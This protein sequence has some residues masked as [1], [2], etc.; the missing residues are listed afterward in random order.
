MSPKKEQGGKRSRPAG[1]AK[2]SKSQRA[3]KT[4]QEPRGKL[5]SMLEYE[6]V[7]RSKGAK[8]PPLTSETSEKRPRPSSKGKSKLRAIFEYEGVTRQEARTKEALRES[9]QKLRVIFDSIAAGVTI[10]DLE[11]N[12]IEMNKGALR[13]HGFSS[14][15]EVIGRNGLELIAEKDRARAIE[16]WTARFKD[17]SDKAVSDHYTLLKADGSQFEAAASESLLRDK[18]G[19]PEGFIT[20]ARDITERKRAEELVRASEAKLRA[21]FESI[22]DA[23]TIVDLEGNIVEVNDIMC[24]M[25]GYRRED[26]IGK[27][28]WDIID[29]QY[30]DTIVNDL[31]KQIKGE[32]PKEAPVYKFS[33]ADGR[34]YYAEL[35]VS[36]IRD[37]SGKATGFLTIHNDITER[38]RMQQALRESEEMARGMLESAAT[39]IYL[40]QDRVFQYVSPLFTEIS[41]YSSSE[42]IGENPLDYVHPEDRENVRKK[43]I[44]DLK[45]RNSLPH[46]FRFMR[47]DGEPV[48]ILEKVASIEY[49]GKPAA[50]ASFMDITEQKRAEAELEKSMEKLRIIIESIGDMLF[51]TDLE[52]KF[53]NVND[54]AVRLLGYGKEEDLIGKS[55]VDC[56]AEKDRSKVAL[57]MGKALA[58]QSSVEI[59]EYTLLT[60]DGRELDAES[61]IDILRDCS[62]QV[63]GLIITTRD[64]TERKRMQEAVRASEEKLSIMFESIRDG[65]VV[66][67]LLGNIIDANEATAAITGYPREKLIGM[68]GLELI[69]PEYHQMAAEVMGK[70]TEGE[71]DT[72][73]LE[74]KFVT[75]DGAEVDAEFSTAI[76]YNGDREATGFVSIARDIGER[77]RME[78]E[79]EKSAEKLRLVIESIGDMLFITDLDLNFSNVN[80]AAV[81]QLGYTT[82]E[83]LAGKNAMEPVVE[84]DRTR[85]AIELGKALAEERGV[86]IIEYS[87]QAVDGRKFDVEANAEILRDC[88]NMV[89]GLIISARD[90]TERKQMLEAIRDSEEKLRGIFDT[91]P[92]GITFTD[93]QGTILELNEAMLRMYG[94]SNKEELIGRNAIDFVSKEYHETV[95]LLGMEA[96][97]EGHDI[98]RIEYQLVNAAG[99][100][101]DVEL[102]AARL[103]DS[104]G[105]P[106][107]WVNVSRDVTERKQAEQAVRESERRFRTIFESIVDGLTVTDLGGNIVD[108]NEAALQLHGY[109]DKQDLIGKNT[110]EY[111]VAEVD[112][113]R[114]IK[115]ALEAIKEDRPLERAEYKL[116]R[117]DGTEFDGEFSTAI[118]RDD[119]GKA[120]GHIGMTRDITERKQAEEAIRQ[121]EEKLRIM[122][123]SMRDAI[124]LTDTTGTIVEVNDAAV[125][126]HGY[127]SRE[128]II[129]KNGLDLVAESNRQQVAEAAINQ[130]KGE[131]SEGIVE[132]HILL[133]ADGT[134]FESESSRAILRDSEGNTTGFISVERD[135]TER[136]QM[137]EQVRDTV[138]KLRTMFDSMNDAATIVDMT[139]NIVDANE[140]AVRLHGY[141]SREEMVGMPGADLIAERERESV[142]KYT[143]KAVDKGTTHER[144]ECTLLKADGTEFDAEMSFSVL[145]DKDGNLDSFLT[146]SQDITERKRAAQALEESEARFRAL[147][148]NMSSAV[149]VYEVK[150]KGKDFIFKDLN[151]AG[152]KISKLNKE[153]VLGK[154]LVDV[155]PNI[156][157]GPIPPAMKRVWKTGKPEYIPPTLYRD[158]R[159]TGWREN[160]IYKLPTGEVVAVYDDVTERIQAEEALRQSE[161]K[162][163]LTFENMRDGI[164]V[165]DLEGKI[166]E[167]NDV[168]LRMSGYSREEF[169]G[170][171][172][173]DIIAN[174]DRDRVIND[175]L[176]S[177]KGEAPEEGLKYRFVNKDGS[178]YDGELHVSVLRDSSGTPTG[179]I[180]TVRDI[181][182][183]KRAEE[184][185]R[186]SEEKLRTMFES[187][188]DSFIVT[189]VET[190]V[191]DVNEAT[192]NTF[193]YSREELIGKKGFDLIAPEDLEKAMGPMSQALETG[194]PIDRMELSILCGDG[195]KLETDFSISALHDSSENVTGFVAAARDISERKRAEQAMRES[196]EKLRRMFESTS[197]G[198]LVTD[199]ALSILETNEAAARML[200][201]DS[202][203]A[204]VGQS[205]IPYM[206]T[207]AG[208]A[209]DEGG[210]GKVQIEFSVSQL[211]DSEGNTTGFI[212]VA[213]DVTERKKAEAQMKR[214]LEDL[215]RSNA[216]LEQFAYI[217]SHDL[218]EPLRMIS[219]YTQLIG[220]RYKD[221]LDADGE[222]FIEYAVDGAT[223]MQDRIQALLTYSRVGTRGKEFEPIDCEDVLNEALSNLQVAIKKSEA[224]IT[225]D[226]LPTVPADGTQ[227]VQ[228]FQ[229]LIENGIKFQDEKKPEVH[230]SA[231]E[232]DEEWLFSFR[233]NG[234]GI[235]PEYSDRI[236]LIFKKLHAKGEYAGTGVGLALCKKIVERHGGRIWVE[237]ELGK[238]ATFYF[239][240]LKERKEED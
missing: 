216:E 172:G 161:E 173:W 141:I 39:G 23:V 123:E 71:Q 167:V 97:K 196:E 193:G 26:I 88:S 40:V 2:G 149:A 50:I 91:I 154:N 60:A 10:T 30:R 37:D 69:S 12:I 5:R 107:A 70:V 53:V 101:I 80:E 27:S 205:A 83:E 73:S 7:T 131:I 201:F 31:M 120:A 81:R 202:K 119:A 126:M 137:E 38:I 6:G 99:K 221:K 139:A 78:A 3:Q 36:V 171:D 56:I 9:E 93:M 63:V 224:S 100:Q 55:A 103:R 33:T 95:I 117:A 199:Q 142:V 168:Q 187:T 143:M 146:L 133:R 49:Q 188:N 136:R 135:I 217:A 109:K 106:V 159:I 32:A 21:M 76:L 207:G 211:R 43:A 98:N 230:V 130:S 194:Q 191:I 200:G 105:E 210:D 222:E 4:P 114:T 181:T 19:E 79:L 239:T 129:G 235:D 144:K 29:P 198:I 192:L 183:R 48:W 35:H 218:Q 110:I 77:K 223:R 203:E 108:M 118:L 74:L 229:N 112:R 231:K 184:A 82:Q 96:V 67:D 160:Y 157:K 147:V 94:H 128:E 17:D 41:G 162:L 124:V 28:G 148:N 179:F 164:T 45:G 68:S 150:N 232:Q 156:K 51:V 151:S 42:L 111:M 66:T 24:R 138:Q 104:S 46:E 122:F 86:E 102:Y 72:A 115:E 113:E 75:A 182:E 18:Y 57:D 195:R 34:E 84:E 16:N 89:V 44:E 165:T 140:A 208:G 127:N 15:E 61:N 65:I 90:V 92:D 189:D 204:L 178:E 225:H 13:L 237:S 47:K 152:E 214:M 22:E 180:T 175:V 219:S 11:G 238:G 185:M 197:D 87:L 166:I 134:E 234:I 116:Q 20:I 169:I 121:S 227:M 64:V 174:I 206:S 213:R 58:A 163:R 215:A 177:L 212:G 228:L 170:R 186:E 1:A 25:G 158:D 8:Q 59:L 233:D 145:Y 132:S 226:P 155:F 236:F 190:T 52:L 125:K 176:K 153:D 85:V 62:G 14:K 54:A 209:D 220:R 240:I